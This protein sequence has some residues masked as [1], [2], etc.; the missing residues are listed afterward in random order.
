MVQVLIINL[1]VIAGVLGIK[2]D[3]RLPSLK[4]A[5]FEVTIVTGQ[6]PGPM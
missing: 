2:S 1:G 3:C 4:L 5:G 6:L